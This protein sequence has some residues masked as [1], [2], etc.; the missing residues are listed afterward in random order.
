MALPVILENARAVTR[1]ASTSG[2]FF[3]KRGTFM[4]GDSIRFAI[5]RV[6][7]YGRVL[8]RCRGVVI[9][10][11]PD[12]HGVGV[13]ASITESTMEPVPGP[14]GGIRLRKSARDEPRDFTRPADAA[15]ASAVETARRWSS[16]LRK[17]ALDARDELRGHAMLEWDIPSAVDAGTARSHRARVCSVTAVGLGST[18]LAD[19]HAGPGVRI[20][21]ETCVANASP[22]DRTSGRTPLPRIVVC[23]APV[24]D[25]DSQELDENCYEQG[26]Y[27]DP[28]KA[29]EAFLAVAGESAFLINLDLLEAEN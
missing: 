26:S 15:L 9:R 21:L 12:D 29:F 18:E 22:D 8:Q 23:A 16:L 24:P 20:E 25:E 6:T 2:V 17:K 27:D 1:D 14:R 19:P 10:T 28:T 5:E 13:A 4:Y 3:W 7:E 11:E